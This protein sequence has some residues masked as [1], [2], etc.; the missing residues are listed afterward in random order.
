MPLVLVQ[1]E[2]TIDPQYER[3]KDIE[4]IQYH[5]PNQYKN[6]FIE[7]DYFIYYRGSRRADKQR[8]TPEYF[9]VGKIGKKRIDP[10]SIGDGSKSKL[11]W[12]CDLIDY[13][14]FPKPVPFK[15]NNLTLEG[16]PLNLYQVGVR[17]ITE[18]VFEQILS[19]ANLPISLEDTANIQKSIIDFSQVT[20]KVLDNS[21]SLLVPSS[22]QSKDSDE[23]QSQAPRY[24][25]YSKVYGDRSEEIVF[26]VLTDQAEHRLRWVSK[27]G[28]K[29]GW[30]IEYY[31]QDVAIAIEVK[32]TSGKRFKNLEITAGEWTAAKSKGEHYNLYL[33]ADC[34]SQHPLVQVINNP[35]E[36]YLKKKI[37]LL[38]TNYRMSFNVRFLSSELIAS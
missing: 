28:E 30:D 14:P 3:W 1:N 38:P 17:S 34:L 2:V 10:E 23:S 16:I 9:G 24:S 20:P 6:K 21:A 22:L 12:Y 8:K 5:F 27:A 26:K 4:G 29:P 18:S 13:I 31:Q 25:K 7:G 35:Y 33:V 37:T 36:L 11:E 32:G 15:V 19:Y